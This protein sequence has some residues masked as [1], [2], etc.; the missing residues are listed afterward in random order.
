MTSPEVTQ[1]HIIKPVAS[2]LRQIIEDPGTWQS[3]VPD[4]KPSEKIVEESV[5]RGE[6]LSTKV[7]RARQELKDSK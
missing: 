4:V 5:P 7:E 3:D 6:S 1:E 2:T